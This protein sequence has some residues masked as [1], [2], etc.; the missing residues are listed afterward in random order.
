MSVTASTSSTYPALSTSTTASGVSYNGIS[1]EVDNLPNAHYQLPTPTGLLSEVLVQTENVNVPEY[2]VW[3][4]GQREVIYLVATSS[5]AISAQ[6][7]VTNPSQIAMTNPMEYS[8]V[9]NDTG[10]CMF[11]WARNFITLVPDSTTPVSSFRPRSSVGQRDLTDSQVDLT[12]T[13]SDCQNSGAMVAPYISIGPNNCNVTNSGPSKYHGACSFPLGA[14]TCQAYL[15]EYFETLY[16]SNEIISPSSTAL[17]AAEILIAVELTS[18]AG[19]T[20]LLIPYLGPGLAEYLARMADFE[21]FIMEQS[22]EAQRAA[23]AACHRLPGTVSNLV[24]RYPG[25]D[26]PSQ[27]HLLLSGMPTTT[28]AVSIDFSVASR[29][30]CSQSWE[31]LLG[32]KLLWLPHVSRWIVR[33]EN[34][35]SLLLN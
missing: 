26:P 24:V 12:V 2:N 1:Y 31:K 28:V 22:G 33:T 5:D 15:A 18:F 6:L 13:N 21:S 29:Q 20:P 7:D 35:R 16:N 17:K 4:N 3:Y 27:T 34:I 8:I 14:V 9:V 30:P 23:T 10:I 32:F 11:L 25:R 19:S